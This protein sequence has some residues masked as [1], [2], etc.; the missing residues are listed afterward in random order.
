[1]PH[2]SWITPVVNSPFINIPGTKTFK[3][4][5]LRIQRIAEADLKREGQVC[6]NAAENVHCGG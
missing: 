1:M 6:L 2:P 3:Y 5:A 4:D